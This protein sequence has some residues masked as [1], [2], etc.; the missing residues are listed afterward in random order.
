MVAMT[1]LPHVVHVHKGVLSRVALGKPS[2]MSFLPSHF[3]VQV[4]KV[5]VDK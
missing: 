5:L 4:L 1:I 2:N 3:S